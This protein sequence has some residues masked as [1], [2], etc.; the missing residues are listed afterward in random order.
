MDKE[1]RKPHHFQTCNLQP[2]QQSYHHAN[3]IPHPGPNAAP[4]H[5]SSPS[6]CGKN[7]LP[8]SPRNNNPLRAAGP[9][10]P[11][12]RAAITSKPHSAHPT[13]CIISNHRC[14]RWRGILVLPGEFEPRTAV[15]SA[16]LLVS[17][18]KNHPPTPKP[19]HYD[20]SYMNH[21]RRNKKIKN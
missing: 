2:A 20:T 21:E 14:P 11:R 16:S 12:S 13:Q 1:P 5:R 6:K 19:S 17:N 3:P 4:L 8:R 15:R 9:R 10:R 7:H 18:C